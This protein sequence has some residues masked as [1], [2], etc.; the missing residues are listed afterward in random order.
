MPQRKPR[1]SRKK[2]KN[3]KKEDKSEIIDYVDEHGPE[4]CEGARR[5]GEVEPHRQK[6]KTAKKERSAKKVHIALLPDRY[7]PLEED[8]T[9]LTEKE[10]EST[11]KKQKYKKFRK[12]V[13]KA[14]R[15]S[16]KCLVVGLQSFSAAYSGPLSAAA[17]LVPQVQRT[18]HR[19]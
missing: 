13:G 19:A 17:T 12:N 10:E 4:K 8:Q 1:K 15:Y 7:E 2:S 14:F 6:K 3:P 18:S 16:W 11:K 9:D 5:S